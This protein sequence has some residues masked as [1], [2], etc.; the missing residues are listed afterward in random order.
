[1]N[2]KIPPP[3]QTL[4][5]AF[6]MWV[7][8]LLVPMSFVFDKSLSGLFVAILAVLACFL[9][10]PALISFWKSN[11]TVN[12]LQPEKATSLVIEGV[13]RFTRNPMYLGMALILCAWGVYLA[14]PFGLVVLFLYVF[15]MNAIQI[16]PEERALLK[17]FGDEY[18][19]YCERVRRWI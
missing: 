8:D 17:L 19:S 14:N 16:K 7:I 2:I 15:V 6:L 9:L 1:M 3:I 13:Y 12:P 10:L 4:I 11:T 18:Q 5:A